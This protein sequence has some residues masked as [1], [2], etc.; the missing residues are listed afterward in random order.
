MSVAIFI[1]KKKT[2]TFTVHLVDTELMNTARTVRI[3][4]KKEKFNFNCHLNFTIS[5]SGC[6]Y[7]PTTCSITIKLKSSVEPEICWSGTQLDSYSTVHYHT[8]S[9]KM[10]LPWTF[11]FNVQGWLY[12]TMLKLRCIFNNLPRKVSWSNFIGFNVSHKILFPKLKLRVNWKSF[13]LYSHLPTK[14]IS[15]P[16]LK[17]VQFR[18]WSFGWCYL[19]KLRLYQKT[20]L[21]NIQ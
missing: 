20:A 9:T 16:T 10:A 19:T 6:T 7:F 21:K 17:K 13:H 2:W 15:R 12:L 18:H 5:L 8:F 4:I 3:N 1:D 11:Q 14:V